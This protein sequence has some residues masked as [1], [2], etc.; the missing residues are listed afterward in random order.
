MY[1][2]LF[3]YPINDQNKGYVML[4]L[5]NKIINLFHKEITLEDKI[6]YLKK[7]KIELYDKKYNREHILFICNSVIETITKYKYINTFAI[8]SQNINVGAISSSSYKSKLLY[9]WFTED[10]KIIV[11]SQEVLIEFLEEGYKT[12]QIY[13]FRI[14]LIDIGNNSYSNAKKIS[15]YYLEYKRIVEYLYKL[16]TT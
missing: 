12:L 2:F 9:E 11:N 7:N 8:E 13:E 5:L 3:L 4:N 15:P 1:N 16:C 14:Q 6:N 10:N